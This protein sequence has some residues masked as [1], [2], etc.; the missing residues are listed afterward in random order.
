M[1][2]LMHQTTKASAPEF[3]KCEYKSKSCTG[4]AQ[5]MTT[6]P[7]QNSVDGKHVEDARLVSAVSSCLEVLA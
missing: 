1:T 7:M 4:I 3:R 5:K 2:I 6:S